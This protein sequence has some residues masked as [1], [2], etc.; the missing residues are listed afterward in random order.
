MITIQMHPYSLQFSFFVFSRKGKND[1]SRKKEDT[2]SQFIGTMLCLWHHFNAQLES[3]V[4][5]LFI[6]SSK[7]SSFFPLHPY[8]HLSLSTYA[9]FLSSSLLTQANFR[10]LVSATENIR[11]VLIMP[12]SASDT[13]Y[14]VLYKRLR[15]VFPFTSL[16]NWFKINY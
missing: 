6:T 5:L 10:W 16:F 14:N 1:P 7:P 2:R 15:T 8:S 12:S 11:E 4:E 9:S 13:R 3:D